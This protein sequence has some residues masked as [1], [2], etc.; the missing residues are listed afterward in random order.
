MKKTF[1]ININGSIFHIE[2]DAYEVLQKYLVNLKN[3]FGNSEEGK[4]ILDDIEARIAEICS[5]KSEDGKNLI[6]L[7]LVNEVIEMMGTPENFSE[8]QEDSEPLAGQRKSKKRLYRD[9][10]QRVLGG[11]CGGLAAYFDIDVALM[12]IIFVVLTLITTG[13]GV[14]AYIILWIAVPKAVNTAQRLEMR[15]QNVSV[16][17]IEKFIKEEADAIKDSYNKFRKSSIFS[18]G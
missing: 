17:N 4:E 2:E 13:A 7:D 15:G 8:E 5:S 3:H 18:K 1:T 10:E 9:P 11:V 12:R 16:K 14:F 6:T